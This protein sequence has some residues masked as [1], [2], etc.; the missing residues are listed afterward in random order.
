MQLSFFDAFNEPIKSFGLDDVRKHIR[1]RGAFK[2]HLCKGDLKEFIDDECKSWHGGF[3]GDLSFQFS[4]KGI[5]FADHVFNSY[6]PDD[7]VIVFN[8]K[9][10]VSFVAEVLNDAE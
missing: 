7:D 4:G 2:E 8:K 10:F 1:K 9:D 6:E 3:G 5:M